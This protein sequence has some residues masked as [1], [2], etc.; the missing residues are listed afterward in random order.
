MYV[1]SIAKSVDSGSWVVGDTGTATT[2]EAG[3]LLPGDGN[4][5]CA[6]VLL[7]GD[8]DR[9]PGEGIRIHSIRQAEAKKRPVGGLKW[10]IAKL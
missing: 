4:A 3:M 9:R 2:E 7:H 1:G 6:L 10:L 8:N 5:A